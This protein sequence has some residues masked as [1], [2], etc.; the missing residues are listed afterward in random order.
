MKKSP[1]LLILEDDIEVAGLNSRLLK[2]R[3]FDTIVAYSVQEAREMLKSCAP[4]LLVLDVS[5]PDGSGFELCRELRASADTPVLFLTGKTEVKDKVEG[6]NIGGDY[7]LTKPYDRDEFLAAVQSLLRRAEHTQKRI[8]E[9]AV[10]K[11]GCLTIDTQA[12]RAYM[13]GKNAILT[14]TEFDLLLVLIRNEN[15]GL[16]SDELYSAVW[17]A[18]LNANTSTLRKTISSLRKKIDEESTDDFSIVTS[19]G[20][21]YMFTTQ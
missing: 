12:K 8:D 15:R 13:N 19:Y 9:A 5:L 16:A 7:Y 17:N 20:K 11:R 1:L 6:L 18:P 21:G 10:I 14:P 2:R 3:G 4:D